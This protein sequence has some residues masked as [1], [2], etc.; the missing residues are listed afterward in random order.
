VKRRIF[1]QKAPE[2]KMY[3]TGTYMHG[4]PEVTADNWGKGVDYAEDGEATEATLR[5]DSEFI[6]APVKTDSAEEAYER[7]LAGVGASLVRDA[8]DAR[9]IE[10]IRTGTA[11]YGKS[12]EGGGNGII[13][14][15][16]D[17][18]GWPDLKSTTPPED[19]DHDGMP[20][21][22]EKEKGLNPADGADGPL[23]R[24]DDGYT[25]LE[26]YLNFLAP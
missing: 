3:L 5:V 25:N 7:V 13:D 10:E 17:V 26:E 1:V 6:V 18:G 21:T 22:W 4:Y 16:K 11:K 9:I 8:V 19:S 12:F 23:D 15:Q 24:D 14:S 2:G 20:D